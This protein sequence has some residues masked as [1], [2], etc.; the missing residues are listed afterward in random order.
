LA[1]ALSLIRAAGEADDFALLDSVVGSPERYE[2]GVFAQLLLQ[3]GF[4]AQDRLLVHG[5]LAVRALH[6][7]LLSDSPVLGSRAQK[8]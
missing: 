1:N 5:L 4:P 6:C 7:D 8:G 3:E 2:D